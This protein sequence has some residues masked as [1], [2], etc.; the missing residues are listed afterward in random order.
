MDFLK[1]IK[2]KENEPTEVRTHS[3]REVNLCANIPTRFSDTVLGDFGTEIENEVKDFATA[4]NNDGV[5]LISGSV[6]VGKTTLLCGALHERD[7]QGRSCGEYLSCR[8]LCAKIRTS[9]SFSAKINE[10]DLLKHFATVPF[11]CIDELGKAEDSE[12]ERLF[13]CNILASRYD[14]MLPTM[15]STNMSASQVKDFILGP[16]GSGNDILDRLSSVMQFKSIKGES[17]RCK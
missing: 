1:D 16:N 6:G 14:N 7:I 11:L 17:F 15:I 9:R 8:M 4:F 3:F 10:E 12:Q 13:I 5:M 2:F